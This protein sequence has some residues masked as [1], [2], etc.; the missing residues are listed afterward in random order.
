MNSTDEISQAMITYGVV[1]KGVVAMHSG[2][3]ITSILWATVVAFIIDRRLDKAS[4][5]F[6]V[7]SVLS[8]F[9]FIH[10]PALVV[11]VATMSFPYAVGYLLAAVICYA[12]HLG[13]KKIMDVPRRYDYV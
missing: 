4:I 8:F 3:I 10:S 13:H 6:V 9:G 1:W 7:A 11:G 12:I 2:A 5:A